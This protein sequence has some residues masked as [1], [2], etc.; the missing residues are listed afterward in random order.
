[1]RIVAA[2]QSAFLQDRHHLV[3]EAPE[4]AGVAGMDIQPVERPALE[5]AADLVSHRRWCADERTAPA[6]ACMV[7][8]LS[9]GQPAGHSAFG[10]G[11]GLREK[12]EA[13]MF[14][15]L[16]RKWCIEIVLPE[17]VPTEGAAKLAQRLF[18]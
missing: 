11:L 6:A 14:K 17:I 9:Q 7:D 13:G 2:K 8:H 12:A 10:N 1:M 15:R 16:G 3:R 18:E 5:P 4:L